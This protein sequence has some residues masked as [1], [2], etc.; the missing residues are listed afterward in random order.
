MSGKL[1]GYTERIY[2]QDE[3]NNILSAIED[4]VNDLGWDYDRMSQSGQEIYNQLDE[5]IQ[6]L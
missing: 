6:N 4:F 1:R 2:T 5:Y 3:V